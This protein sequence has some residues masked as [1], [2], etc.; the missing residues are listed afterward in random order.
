MPTF[1]NFKKN[2]SPKVSRNAAIKM[3]AT[4]QVASK[5]GGQTEWQL[6][7]RRAGS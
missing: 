2:L 1:D 7:F 6:I 4:I 3:I 5:D